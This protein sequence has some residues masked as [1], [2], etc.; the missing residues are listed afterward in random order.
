[1][2]RGLATLRIC[3]AGG[4]AYHCALHGWAAHKCRQMR[5]AAR[6]I[7]HC[8]KVPAQLSQ[9][10]HSIGSVRDQGQRYAAVRQRRPTSAC[11]VPRPLPPTPIALRQWC[12]MRRLPRPACPYP[13]GVGLIRVPRPERRAPPRPVCR[14]PLRVPQDPASIACLVDGGQDSFGRGGGLQ[15]GELRPTRRNGI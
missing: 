13:P 10:R 6:G 4:G 15:V 12:R 5:S 2:R 3:G 7:A 9:R 14:A 11:R 1:M 8:P